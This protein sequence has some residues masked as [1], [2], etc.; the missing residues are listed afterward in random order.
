MNNRELNKKILEKVK[1]KVAISNFEKEERPMS[2]Q[3]ILKMV[4]TFVIAIGLAA[5]ITYAGTAIYENVFTNPEKIE[6]YIDELKVN[7]EELSKIISEKE[8]INKAVEQLKRYKIDLRTNDIENIELQK[9]PNYDE[10]TYVITANEHDDFFVNA[11]TGNLNH[12]QIED[13]LSLEEVEKC[14]SNREDMIEQARIKLKEYGY[15]ESEYKLSYVSSND[16]NDEE[17][18]YMWYISFSKEYDGIFNR[19]QSISMTIIPKIN[20]VTTFSINDEPFENNEIKISMEE[21]VE[22]A[23]EKDKVINSENYAQKGVDSKLEIVRVNPEVYLK[24]NGLE[25][26]NETAT[27]ED[28]TIYSYNTYKM[29]GRVRKAY[30]ISIS[31]EN[32]PFGIPRTYYVDCTTG[33]VIGGE[34]IFDLEIDE[35]I[36]D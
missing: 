10:I 12:F 24:E 18:S 20:K 27:L 5:G 22:I 14:T 21:A 36:T 6:N 11:N 9:A 33:E 19:Y 1:L 30:V 4:A 32:R 31:Y 13:G 16:G 8:A 2:K 17:K 15:D 28:G 34:D 23:K 26:G 29:N 3:K 35:N 25:N 7:E